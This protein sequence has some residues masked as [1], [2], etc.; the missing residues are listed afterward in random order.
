M[1]RRWM[2]AGLLAGVLAGAGCVTVVGNLGLGGSRR[3]AVVL[4]GRI[5]IVDT[6][7]GEV[8]RL[9]PDQ[10]EEA[11]VFAPEAEER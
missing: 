1:I 5:Y 6:K 10:I 7:S 4:D 9:E 8:A 3:E 2:V 11:P